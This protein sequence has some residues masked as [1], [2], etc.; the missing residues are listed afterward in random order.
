MIETSN[1]SLAFV[2][3]THY[4]KMALEFTLPLSLTTRIM[5]KVQTPVKKITSRVDQLPV[6]KDKLI[7]HPSID[8]PDHLNLASAVKNWDP[9]LFYY[10]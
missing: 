1:R 8:R 9:T 6:K 2:C 5:E 4:L 7:S 10:Y 3:S